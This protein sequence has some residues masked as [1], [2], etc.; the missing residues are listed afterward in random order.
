[1]ALRAP[2][3]FSYV[4]YSTRLSV[5][6][7]SCAKLHQSTPYRADKIC[8]FGAKIKGGYRH[9]SALRAPST[10]SYVRYSTRLSVS[11]TSCAKLHQST[12]YRADKICTFGAK[13]KGGYRHISALRGC[14]VSVTYVL[15]CARRRSQPCC[16]NPTHSTDLPPF[17]KQGGEGG[18]PSRRR[19]MRPANKSQAK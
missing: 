17:V 2:S 12:P 13:I 18:P 15:V 16:G 9:I 4:R 19:W 8:T 3:T 5:S 1:M 14:S 7:T 6:V 11:V 10:F